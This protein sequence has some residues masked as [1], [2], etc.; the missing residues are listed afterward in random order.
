MVSYICFKR[1]LFGR[2]QLSK[3]RKD[4]RNEM[5]AGKLVLANGKLYLF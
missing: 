3:Q 2:G 5:K 4:S 1:K